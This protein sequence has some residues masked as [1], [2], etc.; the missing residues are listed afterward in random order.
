M[1]L[2]HVCQQISVLYVLFRPIIREELGSLNA[3]T[4][5]LKF[6]RSTLNKITMTTGIGKSRI[7]LVYKKC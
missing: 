5:I 1:F 3:R 7:K 2:L 6:S 4:I